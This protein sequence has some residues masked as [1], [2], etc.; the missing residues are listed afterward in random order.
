VSAHKK[1]SVANTS[2]FYTFSVESYDSYVSCIGKLVEM[3]VAV[4]YATHTFIQ[5]GRVS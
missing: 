1:F 4:D 2:F 3:F 5:P